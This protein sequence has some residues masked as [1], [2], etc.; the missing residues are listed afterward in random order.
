[1]CL[2]FKPRLLK[3]FMVP[4]DFDFRL[5][6]KYGHLPDH[7]IVV[8]TD[9]CHILSGDLPLCHECHKFNSGSGNDNAVC[10]FEG[11]R[12]I[13]KKVAPGH[14]KSLFVFK[15]CNFLDPDMVNFFI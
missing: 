6:A 2:I 14:S 8:Q 11:F 4:F 9:P 12:K 13:Q 10:Q 7:S 5:Y 15:E 1:M 3:F